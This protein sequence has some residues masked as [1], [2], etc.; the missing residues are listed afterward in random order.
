[1]SLLMAGGLEEVNINR[2]WRVV[3]RDGMKRQQHQ[4]LNTIAHLIHL[5][6]V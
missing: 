3:A 1:M 2:L 5:L 4:A 6:V